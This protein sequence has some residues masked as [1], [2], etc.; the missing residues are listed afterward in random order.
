M[1]LILLLDLL[2]LD[3]GLRMK[4]ELVATDNA[5]YP[6]SAPEGCAS[7]PQIEEPRL[8]LAKGSAP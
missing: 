1:I 5:S 4:P 7:G 3:L 6:G 8:R 2:V